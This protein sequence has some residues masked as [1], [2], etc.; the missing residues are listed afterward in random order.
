MPMLFIGGKPGKKIKNLGWL[1]KHTKKVVEIRISQ[2]SYG[3]GTMIAYLE[4]GIFV[5]DW[6]SYELLKIWLRR[7]SM[8]GIPIHEVHRK[9][10]RK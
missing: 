10:R 8:K 5:V 2:K 9:E 1:L 6:E 4:N 7:P 3:R